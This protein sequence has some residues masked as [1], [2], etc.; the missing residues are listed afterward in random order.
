[1]LTGREATPEDVS[2]ATDLPVEKI[3][4]ILKLPEEPLSADTDEGWKTVEE[5]IERRTPTPEEAC[6]TLGLQSQVRKL[7][8]CLTPREERVIRMRFGINVDRDYTLEEIGQLF[9]VTRE[10]IRQI[11]AKALKKLGHPC[12][13]N[14]IQGLL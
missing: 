9:N 5:I 2:L 12:R 11:E 13:I 10:R 7:L 4:K 14:Y 8:K 1:M 3:L 6:A